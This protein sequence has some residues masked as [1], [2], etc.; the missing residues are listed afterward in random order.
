ML[1]IINSHNMGQNLPQEL[2][3]EVAL[4]RTELLE[5]ESI[6]VQLTYINRTSSSKHLVVPDLNIPSTV[7]FEVTVYQR[8]A[9]ITKLKAE[10][11]PETFE[12]LHAEPEERVLAPGDTACVLLTLS[13]YLVPLEPGAYSLKINFPFRSEN[14]VFRKTFQIKPSKH[15][16]A[17]GTVQDGRLVGFTSAYIAS[18]AVE[19]KDIVL[20]EQL[21][22]FTQTS[23]TGSEWPVRYR[24]RVFKAPSLEEGFDRVLI[25]RR[26]HTGH[27]W[28]HLLV[29]TGSDD[30][31]VVTL[32]E[33]R[34]VRRQRLKGVDGEPID[35]GLVSFDEG[36]L[37]FITAEKNRIRRYRYAQ[38]EQVQLTGTARG[39]IGDIW[40]FYTDAHRVGLLYTDVSR[41]RLH[42]LD[43]KAP[44][45]QT[46]PLWKFENSILEI[47]TSAFLDKSTSALLMAV[48]QSINGRKAV[49]K[50][51]RWSFSGKPTKADVADYETAVA[52][53]RFAVSSNGACYMIKVEEGVWQMRRMEEK[54]E[55]CYAVEAISGDLVF[56]HDE[57]GWITL[58]E[59]SH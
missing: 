5:G 53:I 7:D 36:E 27:F 41:N 51:L 33:G 3:V 57:G 16:Q 39:R 8:E 43:I 21:E 20:V 30:W 26:S 52:S 29:E 18:S 22:D 31:W 40:S 50:M 24:R 34:P 15:I 4:T 47:E 1:G 42:A 9:P 46:R 23:S 45:F 35:Q 59:G 48:L 37:I 17:A 32:R 10:T 13:S 11:L 56:T 49:V 55:A 2:N 58:S 12:S 28:R 38:A 19:K 6:E 44:R 54:A 14:S 25:A